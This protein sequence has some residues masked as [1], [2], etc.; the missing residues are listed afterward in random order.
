MAKINYDIQRQNFEV[1]RENIGQI[2][3]DEF[4][5]QKTNLENEFSDDQVELTVWNERFIQFDP[6]EMP[7][8]NVSYYRTT[9]EDYSP[10][11]RQ[12]INDYHIDIHAAAVHERAKYGDTQAAQICQRLAGIVSYLLMSQEYRFLGF[13]PGFIQSRWIESIDMGKITESDAAHTI[14][15]RLLF[16]VKANETVREV[17]PTDL[18]AI[19]TTV[20]LDETDK[21]HYFI[22]EYNI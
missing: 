12:G 5:E 1:I 10:V 15:S 6:T 9:Y 17:P 16:R 14:V 3:A 21:G 7:A 18:E 19:H 8:V 20:K 4:P 11:D 13:E 2:L 22:T